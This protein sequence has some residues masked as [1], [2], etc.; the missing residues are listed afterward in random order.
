MVPDIAKY[1]DE[2]I[3]LMSTKEDETSK[4]N[5]LCR[6]PNST[7][8]NIKARL[9]GLCSISRMDDEFFFSTIP[10]T[11]SAWGLAGYRWQ[12][13]WNTSIRFLGAGAWEILGNAY[14]YYTKEEILTT[15]K[16]SVIHNYQFK[17]LAY[18]EY[19]GFIQIRGKE[20]RLR[21]T[22]SYMG[23]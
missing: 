10:L 20:Y 9:K 16:L 14:F 19:K 5:V 11:N 21:K 4:R 3:F 23:L 12:G 8:T 22:Q 15:S 13:K 2:S 7:S 6:T 18:R 17:D 1:R